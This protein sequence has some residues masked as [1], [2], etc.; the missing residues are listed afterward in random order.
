MEGGFYGI[1]ADSGA[2][3]RPVNLPGEFAEDGLRVRFCAEP[4]EGVMSFHMWGIPVQIVEME[5]LQTEGK[6]GEAR[7]RQKTGNPRN[8]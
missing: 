6:A 2:R 5:P 4:L 8:P 3:Y 1:R 7:D